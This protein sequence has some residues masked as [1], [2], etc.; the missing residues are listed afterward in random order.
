MIFS[1]EQGAAPSSV[2]FTDSPEETMEVGRQIGKQLNPGNILFFF[3][4]LGA[5]KTTLIKSLISELTGCS[6]DEV[7]SPTFTYVHS[8]D[9]KKPVHHFDLYRLSSPEEFL[10]AGFH[11]LLS[12]EAISLIEWPDRLPKTVKETLAIKLEYQDKNGRKISLIPGSTHA[13]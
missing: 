9:S 3:G 7:T 4:E 12:I 10:H 1:L 6:P 2:F 5:G 11:E 8:Y 13:T